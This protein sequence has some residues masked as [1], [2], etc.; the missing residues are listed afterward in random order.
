MKPL[1]DTLRHYWLAQRMAKQN[2]LDLAQAQD[3][4]LLPQ[5]D[6]AAMVHRCRGCAW[7]EGCDRWL[8]ALEH[9][10]DLPDECANHDRFAAL[11]TALQPATTKEA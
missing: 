2:G 4:G 8:D 5:R 7:T 1:G 6:W 10:A 3:Q 9:G 11:R